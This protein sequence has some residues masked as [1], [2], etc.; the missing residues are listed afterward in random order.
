MWYHQKKAA[1]HNQLVCLIL[2]KIVNHDVL[3]IF[4]LIGPLLLAC[5]SADSV[6]VCPSFSHVFLF[7]PADLL[8][9][10]SIM[11]SFQMNLQFT[12]G[13]IICP[14]VVLVVMVVVVV[15]VLVIRFRLIGSIKKV[16]APT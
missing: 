7:L 4:I 13:F 14:V 6:D 11:K 8:N 9:H 10:Y 3:L 5:Q 2:R 16:I 12:F 15:V 1:T